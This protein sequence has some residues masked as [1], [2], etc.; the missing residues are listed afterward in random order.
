MLG[1]D[2]GAAQITA[3]DGTDQ[4]GGEPELATERTVHHDHVVDIDERWDGVRVLSHTASMRGSAP[5][6]NPQHPTTGST[7]C[8][9]RRF[10]PGIAHR[11]PRIAGPFPF[12]IVHEAPQPVAA[13][14]Q[15][16]YRGS[17]ARPS[18]AAA[19]TRESR[20]NHDR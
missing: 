18:H 10:E 7:A 8:A 19:R 6:L 13:L 17:R 5:R 16:I 20:G 3:R 2:R 15:R 11:R 14:V 1:D 12:P 4:T 9:P